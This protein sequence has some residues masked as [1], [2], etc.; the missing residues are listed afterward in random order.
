MDSRKS[1]AFLLAGGFIAWLCC[2]QVAYSQVAPCT[3]LAQNQISTV[4]GSG[5][6]AGSPIANTGCSWKATGA[7]KVVVTVSMQTEKMFAGAKSSP[8]PNMTKTPVSG[9]GDEAFFTGVQGFASLWVRKGTTFPL[10]RI[11]GLPINEAQTK[12]RALATSVLS[13]L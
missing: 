4:I 1:F 13:K 11:Y 2:S 12:L 9:L 10:V 3:L 5:V 6:G 8:A 7:S